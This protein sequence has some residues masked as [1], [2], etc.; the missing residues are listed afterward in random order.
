MQAKELLKEHIAKTISL[1]DEQFDYLFSHFKL[2]SFKKGQ[3]IIAAGDKVD[4]EYFVLDGCLKSFY[5]NDDLKMFILQ[6]AMPTWWSSD[7]NALYSNA[8]ATI[9]LDCITDAEVLC[10]SNDDREKLC[11]EIH[12]VEHFFRWRT[13]KGYVASQKRL[14]SFMN[15]DAKHRY[16]ELLAQYPALYNI[17]PKHLIAAYLGVSRETLSRLYQH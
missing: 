2:Q 3:V 10:L 11:N 8:K 1:T 12:Q 4:H 13:N 6:F 17:V 5:I 16:E 15:N 9:N 14:L 7:Y